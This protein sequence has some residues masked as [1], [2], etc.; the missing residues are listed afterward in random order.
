MK[1]NQ[2]KNVGEIHKEQSGAAGVSTSRATM[3]G[4][5]QDMGFKP[6]L[7]KRLHQKHVAWAR[8]ARL[9]LLSG[10]K[11]CSL[12]KVNVAFPLVVK[13]RVWRE[14][15]EAQDP[16]CFRSSVKFSQSVMVWVAM[17]SAGV[18]RCVFFCPRS[19]QPTSLKHFMVAFI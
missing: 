8:S 14:R 1:E 11:L 3:H 2:F 13:L 19:T 6:L 9:L 4:C 17:S 18:V 7:N 15:G 12:I 16:R 5:M 10:P